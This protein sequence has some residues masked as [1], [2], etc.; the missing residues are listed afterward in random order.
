MDP[1]GEALKAVKYEG[2]IVLETSC[3][4]K[5]AEA[6]C[7]RNAEFVRKLMGVTA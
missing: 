2:W 5:N 7:K 1:V 6:D 3:P 4:S